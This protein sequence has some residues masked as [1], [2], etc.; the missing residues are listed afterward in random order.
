MISRWLFFLAP[1]GIEFPM[2]PLGTQ[3]GGFENQNQRSFPSGSI[4]L[5]LFVGGLVVGFLH[6]T[7]EKC[8]TSSGAEDRSGSQ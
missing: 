4:A 6:C 8:S 3:G 2:L 7:H 5:L 1:P